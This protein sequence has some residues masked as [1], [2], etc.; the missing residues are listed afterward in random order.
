MPERSF[1]VRISRDRGIPDE[2]NAREMNNTPKAG[3]VPN[4]R[5]AIQM[6]TAFI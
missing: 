1:T 2:K 4:V 5:G 3:R 6:R